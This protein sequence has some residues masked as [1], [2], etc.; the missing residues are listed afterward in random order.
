[1]LLI[2]A[3]PRCC[4]PPAAATVAVA[5]AAAAPPVS[6]AIN[7]RRRLCPSPAGRAAPAENGDGVPSPSWLVVG[8]D[9]RLCYHMKVDKLVV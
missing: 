6:I 1:M 5:A 3:C 8:Q 7:H 4:R 9:G 2:V